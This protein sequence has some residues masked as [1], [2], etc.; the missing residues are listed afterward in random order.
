M[1]FIVKAT[2]PADIPLTGAAEHGFYM[3]LRCQKV[4]EREDKEG[5]GYGVCSLCGS[6][7]I[8]WVPPIGH[9]N[10]PKPRSN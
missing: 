5:T 1:K 3:C 8:K 10:E 9:A 4:C 7:R 6:Y 2:P